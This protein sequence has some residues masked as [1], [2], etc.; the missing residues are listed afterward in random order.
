MTE[1]IGCEVAYIMSCYY[2]AHLCGSCVHYRGGGDAHLCWSGH[3][4]GNVQSS[5][6]EILLCWINP[7]RTSLLV[8]QEVHLYSTNHRGGC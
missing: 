1:C 7:L 3:I 2:L 4:S 8:Y 5:T 6:F